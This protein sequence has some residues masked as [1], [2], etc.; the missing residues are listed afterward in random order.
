M[1]NTNYYG[2]LEYETC[3]LRY[4]ISDDLEGLFLASYLYYCLLT[5]INN[6]VFLIPGDNDDGNIK[7][8]FFRL[9]CLIKPYII[10]F[11]NIYFLW[12]LIIPFVRAVILQE[13]N[14]VCTGD[15]NYY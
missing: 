9:S 10:L 7:N 14:Q 12:R 15:F 1:N 5:D 13:E 8:L 3:C 6:F 2:L 11:I 4:K